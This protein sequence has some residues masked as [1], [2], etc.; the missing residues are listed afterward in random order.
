MTTAAGEK[1]TTAG[2]AS[3][4]ARRR[5]WLLSVALT[6][7][8]FATGGLAASTL[9][10]SPAQV[11]AETRPPAPSLLTAEVVREKLSATVVMRGTYNSGRRQA[12]TPT[13]AAASANGPGADVLMVTAVK[14]KAGKR[15][16]AGD[17][18]LEV[19]ERPVFVL[20]GAFPAYRDLM[21]GRSGKDVDQ[22][23]DALR[24]LGYGSYDRAGYFGP[25]AASAVRRFYRDLGYPVALAPAEAAPAPAP[26]AKPG[27]AKPKPQPQ[28]MVPRSEV[29]FLPKLP[30]RIAALSG[31][32]GDAVKEPLVTFST[33]GLALTARAD[34]ESAALIRA[35]MR[36]TV[37]AEGN[38][39][40]GAG[41]V[42]SIGEQTAGEAKEE[43]DESSYVPVRIAAAKAWPEDLAAAEARVTI[44]TASTSEEVLAVPQAAV[45]ATADGQTWV[46]VIDADE[47]PRVVHV[48]AG[49]SADGL[50]EV[51]PTDGE[52]EPG[53]R[54]VTGG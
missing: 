31:G 53:D 25:S 49:V 32:V 45:S 6:A 43:G 11:A 41:S 39:W 3:P 4:L 48:T 24:E 44:T 14:A 7:V 46:T 12:F 50:V 34:P 30:A 35:G 17:V 18:V 27:A 5:R 13:D 9:V 10:K 2:A 47:S 1:T 36:V 33:G 40:T 51:T 29:A 15:V 16:S 19:S 38:G 42:T 23:R 37:V 26:S 54:V 20:P 21:P 8:F 28:P 52:L 22:L